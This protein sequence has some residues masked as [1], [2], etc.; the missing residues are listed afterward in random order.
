MTEKLTVT[1]V[2]RILLGLLFIVSAGQQFFGDAQYIR[3]FRQIG[4][5]DWL[6]YT[7]V[8]LELIGVACLFR[9]KYVVSG[10]STLLV[11]T[12]G[13]LAAQLTVLSDDGGW[14]HCVFIGSALIVLISLTHMQRKSVVNS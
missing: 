8:A 7:T 5:G 14:F 12:T 1:L 3:E 10:A 6:R 13:A 9:P 4:F 11:V 2:L